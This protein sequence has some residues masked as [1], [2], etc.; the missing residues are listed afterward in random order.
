VPENN[1]IPNAGMAAQIHIEIGMTN[2]G[3]SDA[4]DYLARFG[5]RNWALG[6]DKLSGLL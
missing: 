1:G 4:H 2:R 3:G 5:S 6:N